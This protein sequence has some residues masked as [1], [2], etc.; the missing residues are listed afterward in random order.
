MSW[1]GALAGGLGGAAQGA[2]DVYPSIMAS[3]D[4]RRDDAFR[5]TQYADQQRE[6]QEDVAFRNRQEGRAAGQAGW[7]Q[8][9]QAAQIRHQERADEIDMMRL[10]NE[11]NRSIM[12]SRTDS[13]REHY[14][15]RLDRATRAANDA[16][17]NMSIDQLNRIAKL[18]GFSDYGQV[19]GVLQTAGESVPAPGTVANPGETGLESLARISSEPGFTSFGDRY[20][21][22]LDS[23][24]A[25]PTRPDVQS[26]E[27]ENLERIRRLREQG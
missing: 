16:G 3:R 17:P 26:L 8:A 14:S 7:A 24:D 15:A 23:D 2:R 13:A 20:Q 25:D 1:L 4:S 19:V 21:D 12:S 10:Q 9:Y 5:A 27:A 22:Y 6:R 11:I 18:Q